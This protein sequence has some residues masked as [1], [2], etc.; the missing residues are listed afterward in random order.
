MR[1]QWDNHTGLLSLK[2]L[3]VVKQTLVLDS[4]QYISPI[5]T[6]VLCDCEM[7]LVINYSMP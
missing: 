4:F 1:R 3:S 5:I 7:W 2:R 6:R